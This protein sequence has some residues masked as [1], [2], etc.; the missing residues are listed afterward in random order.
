LP[1]AFG[2]LPKPGS[3]SAS[4]VSAY[5]SAWWR[6]VDASVEPLVGREGFASVEV[7]LGSDS[8]PSRAVVQ[9]EG[10]GYQIKRELFNLECERGGSMRSVLLL[11]TQSYVTQVAKPAA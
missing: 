3:Q 9:N 10:W 5:Q 2:R 6:H 11:Y 1:L 4:A 7:F 8:A